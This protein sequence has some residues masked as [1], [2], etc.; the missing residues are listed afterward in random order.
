MTQL[1]STSAET[2]VIFDLV[3]GD[4]NKKSR[5]IALPGQLNA[6][7]FATAAGNFYEFV[8]GGDYN[9]DKFVQPTDWRDTTGSSSTE[10]EEP[11]TT[12]NVRFELYTVTRTEYDFSDD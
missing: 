9:V 11:W 1:T 12:T 4:G 8:T 5:T 6:T 2:R 10:D 7:A 3:D